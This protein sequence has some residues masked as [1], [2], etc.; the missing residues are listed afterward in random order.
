MPKV[1]VIPS[2]SP[3]SLRL[4]VL[5]IVFGASFVLEGCKSR[6]S[7]SALALDAATAPVVDQAEATYRDANTLHNLRVDYDAVAQF[8]AKDPVYNPRKLEML[9]SDKD[10]DERLAVLTGFQVYVKSLCALTSGTA[11]KELG[12]ASS[13]V[14]GQLSSLANTLVPSIQKTMGIASADSSGSSTAVITPEVQNGISTGLFALGKYLAARKVK[15]ELPAKI[16][17]MDPHVQ[18][19]AT[20]L[21]SD[22]DVLR[23]QEK[24][25]YD[26][27]INLQ[28]LYVRENGGLGADARRVEIMKLPDIVRKQR[29]TD[30][31]L[32][33][34]RGAIA[35]L[36]QTHKELTAQA[37]SRNPE[38]FQQTL[39]NLAN[40]AQDLGTFYSSLS[41]N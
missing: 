39:Q 10:I 15:N 27:I 13:A 30:E 25:D 21:E 6:L 35:L 12:E 3:L 29:A 4:F 23:D 20:L 9:L 40:A 18:A 7:D 24:R 28:T 36:A 33:S 37:Q 19:L 31:R 1:Q 41:T 16:A 34:L 5:V 38:S 11:P 2:H 17:E 8:D 26:R 22:I 14:G 32:A